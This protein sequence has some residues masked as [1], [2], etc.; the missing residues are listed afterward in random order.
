MMKKLRIAFVT[1]EFVSE[2][3]F[4]G[5]LA[6]YVYR[7]A[8][9]LIDRGHEVHVVIPGT[10]LEDRMFDGIH[11]HRLP[12]ERLAAVLN[13]LTFGRLWNT[14]RALAFAWVSYRFLHRMGWRTTIDIVQAASYKACG[15]VAAAFKDK[16][17]VTR[18]SSHLAS[19]NK[20][21]H[22]RR[23]IDLRCLEKLE[24][25]QCRRSPLVFAPSRL[26]AGIVGKETGRPVKVIRT[27]F[28]RETPAA[29][30][31]V[32]GDESLPVN[33]SYILYF[34]RFELLKGFH[35]LAQALPDVFRRV[36]D[37]HVVCVGSDRPSPLASSMVDYARRLCAGFEG[38][39]RFVRALRHNELYPIIEVSRLV[40][41]PS[42]IDNLP[43]T[44][45]EAMALGKPVVGTIG[46][47]YDEVIEE[48]K[49][50]FLV[51]PGSVSGL[52]DKLVEA[53]NHPALE[54]IGKAAARRIADFAP[55]RTVPA[56]LE[57]YAEVMSSG[58]R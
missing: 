42:L 57:C 58:G 55:E 24:E 35:V 3:Y 32:L 29:K 27:P 45:L 31:D 39:L 4:S 46:A 41:L 43:N 28:V 49:N 7:V 26:I 2:R 11:L 17:L 5:G 34:G 8:L 37:C 20:A 36:P 9:A 19:W 56:L 50:G 15:I 1:P 48:G 18:I 40:V 10:P 51:P 21:S 38:R 23:N 14:T 16:R 6:N 53:W 13:V 52:A 44:L 33:A 25:I 54:E 30:C 47:S 22:L 12:F